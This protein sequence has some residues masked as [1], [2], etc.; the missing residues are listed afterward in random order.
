MFH[1]TGCGFPLLQLHIGFIKRLLFNCILPYN[2]VW[3]ILKLYY[4]T[5]R[6]GSL[7]CIALSLDLLRNKT[8]NWFHFDCNDHKMF[9]ARQTRA[10]YHWAPEEAIARRR[11]TNRYFTFWCM[12]G[13]FI[14]KEHISFSLLTTIHQ[15][16]RHQITIGLL[17]H[18]PSESI[19]KSIYTTKKLF[20]KNGN[21]FLIVCKSFFRRYNESKAW[22]RRGSCI[23]LKRN[24]IENPL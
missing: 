8:H 12:E 5:L 15:Y 19:N 6:I 11:Q 7:H 20:I 21:W 13:K 10:H 16:F 14:R 18:K 17:F 24:E 23:S 2:F 4:H 3:I 9:A 1:L 22:V